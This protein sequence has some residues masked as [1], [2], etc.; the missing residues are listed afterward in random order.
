M[1]CQQFLI[2][3]SYAYLHI[4]LRPV[5]LNN[6]KGILDFL[7]P[8][9]PKSPY[10]K[11]DVPVKRIDAFLL[12]DYGYSNSYVLEATHGKKANHRKRRDPCGFICKRRDAISLRPGC[13]L[14]ASHRT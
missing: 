3:W 10:D 14:G 11:A 6:I 4:F 2:Y 5:F 7:A 1:K 13:T 9:I 12:G 8:F